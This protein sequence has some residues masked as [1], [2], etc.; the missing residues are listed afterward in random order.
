MTRVQ[1][2]AFYVIFMKLKQIWT[3]TKVRQID[4]KRF[5]LFTTC[6][7]LT[8][9]SNH[10]FISKS[11]QNFEPLLFSQFFWSLITFRLLTKIR[12]IDPKVISFLYSL[13]K[14]NEFSKY[15]QNP[16]EQSRN[17]I[18]LSVVLALR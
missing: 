15:R 18:E 4:A 3:C 13:P 5:P 6:F 11:R 14:F 16:L 9:F 1:K 12:Q 10:D 2:V 8:Y 17:K 7:N